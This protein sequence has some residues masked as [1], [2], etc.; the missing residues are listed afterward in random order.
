MLFVLSLVPLL[1]KIRLSPDISGV[2]IGK[3]E[4]K[5]AAFAY[6]ILLY[7]TRPR[8]SLPNIMATLLEYGKLS[9]FKFNPNKSKTLGIN[10]DKT[11]DQS[12]QKHFPFMWG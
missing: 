10:I 7:I 1:S 12:Y 2:T 4:Y 6:D 5:L 9:N 11:R 3:D 8:I